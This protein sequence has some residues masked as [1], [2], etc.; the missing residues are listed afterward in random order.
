MRRA[1]AAGGLYFLPV[2]LLGMALGTV[3]TLLIEP[4]LGAVG[5]VLA[6]LP[7]MLAAAW[8]VC[9]RLARRLAVPAAASSRLAMGG[10]AFLLLMAAELALDLLAMGGTVAGHFAAY[11]GGAPLI[12]LLGQ[13]AF[14]L[15]PMLRAV[16]HGRKGQKRE[17]HPSQIRSKTEP[18]RGLNRRS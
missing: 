1:L 16:T 8:F 2:F 17:G 9:G 13:I 15:F 11:R 3:R 18:M 7:F 6:E 12:G 14:A 4:R 5:S 10:A